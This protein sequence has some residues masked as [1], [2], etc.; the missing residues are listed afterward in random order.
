MLGGRSRSASLWIVHLNFLSLATKAQGTG[1]HMC[2]ESSGV[3]RS[4]LSIAS[5]SALA[6]KGTEVVEWEKNPVF[7]ATQFCPL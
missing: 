7:P 4:V 5:D 2:P 6:L 1:T 3:W